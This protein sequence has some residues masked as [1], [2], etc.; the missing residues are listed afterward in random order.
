RH[1][2][3]I[4]SL[5]PK[6]ARLPKP[7]VMGIGR[8]AA[9]VESKG[10][11]QGPRR[12]PHECRQMRRARMRSARKCEYVNEFDRKPSSTRV[13]VNGWRLPDL[14]FS[15]RVTPRSDSRGDSDATPMRSARSCT[16]LI[17]AVPTPEGIDPVAD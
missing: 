8:T 15:S 12:L 10:A 2:E 4:T 13:I 1:S 5:A 9:R 16:G 7:N 14:A 6:R 17:S 3:L 11:W